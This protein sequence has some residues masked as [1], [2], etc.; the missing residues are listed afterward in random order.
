MKTHWNQDEK[1]FIAHHILLLAQAMVDDMSIEL[2]KDMLKRTIRLMDKF[3]PNAVYVNLKLWEMELLQQVVT[4]VEHELENRVVPAIQKGDSPEKE[5]QLTRAQE[6]L[7]QIAEL[8][9]K[10]EGYIEG[11]NA[12]RNKE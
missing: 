10:L 4:R 2:D 3:V 7:S 8:L 11:S 12:A 1:N 5:T 6:L 9:K